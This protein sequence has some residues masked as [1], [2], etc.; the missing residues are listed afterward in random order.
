MSSLDGRTK[1]ALAAGAAAALGAVL[2]LWRRSSKSSAA[3][4]DGIPAAGATP[5]T[6]MVG[7]E[8]LIRIFQEI[9]NS[10]QQVMVKLAQIEQQ[11]K[12]NA[13]QQGKQVTWMVPEHAA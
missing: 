1:L 12:M 13:R 8:K 9:T 11:L 3:P 4:A 10:M 5:E 6:T 7:R 2:L